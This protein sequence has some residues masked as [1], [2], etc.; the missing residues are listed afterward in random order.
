MKRTSTAL[1]ISASEFAMS[2]YGIATLILVVVGIVSFF[3][4][5][6]TAA[7][8]AATDAWLLKLPL[9][10]PFVVSQTVLAFSQTLSVLLENGITAAEAL[11]MTEKQIGNTTHRA[12]FGIATG[13]V[14][15]GEA[16]SVALGRT[17]AHWPGENEAPP[18]PASL[19][20][21]TWFPGLGFGDV[22]LI[23]MV[24]AFLGPVGVVVTILLAALLGLP[25]GL[26]LARGTRDGLAAPFGFGP[27]IAVAA[28]AV[29]VFGPR[30][31]GLPL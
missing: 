6:Q 16:L 24:G 4:W 18:R 9:T 22:K 10:G 7:G 5:R 12:A 26:W 29:A 15:E 2:I 3:G 13:R 31:P 1:L 21:W 19:D 17:F 14:L 25:L 20:Y 11:R 27:P 30:V 8:R 23:G 28:L